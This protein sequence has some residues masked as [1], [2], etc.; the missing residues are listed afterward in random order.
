MF[1]PYYNAI[2]YFQNALDNHDCYDKQRPIFR[3]T[4]TFS[5]CNGLFQTITCRNGY[6]HDASG[7]PAK[8]SY[9]FGPLYYLHG[10]EYEP[11]EYFR[12]MEDQ[13]KHR[14]EWFDCNYPE[15][16]P[17]KYIEFMASA[18]GSKKD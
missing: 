6:V 9:L 11:I 17:N 1:N 3:P 2:Y 12:L 18:L 13:R 5:M 10:N 8:I 4:G 7:N 15:Y 14:P 16:Q